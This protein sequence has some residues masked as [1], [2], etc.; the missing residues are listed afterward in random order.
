MQWLPLLS[1]G[2]PSG[3]S[4]PRKTSPLTPAPSIVTWW[5]GAMVIRT[6]ASSA[7]RQAVSWGRNSMGA[8]LVCTGW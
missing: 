4:R 5:P 7:S 3:R 8:G 1:R 2:V 6:P